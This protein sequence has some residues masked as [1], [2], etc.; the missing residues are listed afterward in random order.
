MDNETI[1]YVVF[2]VFGLLYLF[3]EKANEV[4]PEWFQKDKKQDISQQRFKCMLN[5]KWAS[6]MQTSLG[7]S[8]MIKVFCKFYYKTNIIYRKGLTMSIEMIV[9]TVFGVLYL[10]GEKAYKDH[11]E[12]FQKDKK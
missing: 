3:G 7:S 8:K 10:L 1:V 2:I 6:L 12:W 5:I 4:H 9:Y 11:P